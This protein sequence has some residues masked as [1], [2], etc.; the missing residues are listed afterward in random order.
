MPKY[1]RTHDYTEGYGSGIQV[2]WTPTSK[3]ID[4]SGYYDSCVGIEG[5]SM[6]LRGFF[7]HLGITEKDCIKAFQGK[8]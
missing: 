1:I 7:D 6:S 2:A 5:V 8:Q 3:R 4:I